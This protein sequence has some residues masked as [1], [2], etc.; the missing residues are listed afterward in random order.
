MTLATVAGGLAWALG[1]LGGWMLTV[2][3]VVLLAANGSFLA[4][5]ARTHGLMFAVRAFL[6]HQV[7]YIYSSA[8][9]AAAT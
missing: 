4:F 5:F 7:Y 3:V 1:W 9:F 2:L 8:T 6:F